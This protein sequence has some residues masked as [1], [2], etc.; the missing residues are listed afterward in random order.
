M[1]SRSI[2]LISANEQLADPVSPYT[3]AD[4]ASLVNEWPEGVTAVTQQADGEL[5]YWD[6]PVEDIVIARR[7]A[8]R[9]C[10]LRE[11]G[12]RHQIH[13]AYCNLESPL[14]ACDWESA[15]VI[16]RSRL[17]IESVPAI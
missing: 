7:V 4:I 11:L 6:A 17:S 3:L 9:G 1:T 15:V 8:G 13:S 2:I 12:I 16:V 5:L 14:L 10:L